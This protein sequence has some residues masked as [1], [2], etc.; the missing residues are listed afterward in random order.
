MSEDVI[1]D[2]GQELL[3]KNIPFCIY[4]FPNQPHY[5][6][7]ID[8]QLLAQNTSNIFWISP[9]T[10]E[11][12]SIDIQL[13]IVENASI[14]QDFLNIV[15]VSPKNNPTT[16]ILPP[17]TTRQEY[18]QLIKKF[19]MDIQSG[20][21]KKVILS[22]VLTIDKPE[23]FEPI[24]FFKK[25]SST[26]TKAFNYIFYHPTSGTWAGAAPELL[27]EKHN[28]QLSIMSLAGTQANNKRKET[29]WGNKEMEEHLMVGEHIETIFEK[30]HYTLI[31]KEGPH[32]SEAGKVV[33]LQTDYIYQDNNYSSIKE[34]LKDIHPTPAVGGLPA[35]AAVKYIL[36][37]ENHDRAYYCGIIGE[38]NFAD[39][40]NLYVNLR[41]MQ[42]GKDQIALYVGGGIT[43]SSIPEDEW[44][45]TT[46][47]SE[48][49]MQII[50]ALKDEQ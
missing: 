11:S 44:N 27:L 38:T 16:K 13:N 9:F 24:Q 34:L 30:H 5:N 3:S 37:H 15:K 1:L 12:K 23:Y 43:S 35:K 4:K 18:D 40:A 7:A 22:R 48:T 49:M 28:N 41:C 45:E 14:N 21:L 46:L 36:E 29:I 31:K 2:I 25:L 32:T 42:I 10:Q 19:I 20:Q 47:K 8:K 39:T 50:D 26:Y 6:L 17:A 33:H